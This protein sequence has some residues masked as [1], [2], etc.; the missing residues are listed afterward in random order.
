[1]DR[2]GLMMAL[3]CRPVVPLVAVVAGM[4]ASALCQALQGERVPNEI[5]CSLRP[6]FCTHR[7]F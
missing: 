2:W 1:M 4:A 7:R 6:W 5:I 3:R